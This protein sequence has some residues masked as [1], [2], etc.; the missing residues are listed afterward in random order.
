MPLSDLWSRSRSGV[1]GVH[2][3]CEPAGSQTSS[4]SGGSRSS[5]SD[6]DSSQQMRERER[7]QELD[8]LRRRLRTANARCA[9]ALSRQKRKLEEDREPDT[10]PDPVQ[11]FQHLYFKSN[12]T[13]VWGDQCLHSRNK[14]KALLEPKGR[15]R[16]I[17]CYLRCLVKALHKLFLGGEGNQ[18]ESQSEKP[19]F[20][21]VI[22]ISIADDTDIRLSSGI[23]GSSEIRSILNNNQHVIAVKKGR[24]SHTDS[25]FESRWFLIHQPLVALSR[26]S[27]AHVLAEFLSWTLVFCESVGWRFRAFD[28]DPNIFMNVRRHVFIL[29]GDANKVNDSMFSHMARAVHEHGNSNKINCVA[30]FQVQCLIHQAC[31]TRKHLALGFDSYWSTLVRLGHLF[32]SRTFRKRFYAAVTKVVRDHFDFF[33]VQE[34]PAEAHVWKEAKINGLK[35]FSDAGGRSGKMSRR[36]KTLQQILSKDNGDPAHEQFIHFCTGPNCCPGGPEDAM[37]VLVQSYIELLAFMPVP[38]LY[39]WKHAAVSNNFVRDGFF[40][41]RILPRALE[42]M[43]QIK[44]DLF[45]FMF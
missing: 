34:L 30:A 1:D 26:A 5:G 32:E 20:A 4:D 29:V 42:T 11:N 7:D 22:S 37:G 35:L 41:H 2:A 8:S 25:L 44:C 15:Q 27:A 18:D 21:H 23:R 33:R 38:L 13:W 39:R 10:R 19:E 36:Y 45:G 28:L 6:S 3:G 14:K 24:A 43:P 31:L 17:W 12:A 16:A 40:L 9:A